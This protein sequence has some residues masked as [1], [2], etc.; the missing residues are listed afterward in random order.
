NKIAIKQNV[1]YSR[2]TL[3]FLYTNHL[4]DKSKIDESIELYK[5]DL[6]VE[7]NW[8]SSAALLAIYLNPE[9]F[10]SNTDYVKALAYAR[11]TRDLRKNIVNDPINDRTANVDDEAI[12]LLPRSLTYEQLQQAKALYLEIT[13]KMNSQS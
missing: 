2:F 11:I 13:E 9:E 1:K 4:K 3:A 5:E 8:E 7:K 10:G 6:L 12:E